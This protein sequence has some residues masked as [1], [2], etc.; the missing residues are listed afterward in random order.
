M[1]QKR[2]G[3]IIFL[4]R[5]TAG[6][7]FHCYWSQS[8]QRNNNSVIKQYL[9]RQL[10][11]WR[12]P[13]LELGLKKFQADLSTLLFW[14]FPIQSLEERILNHR[15]RERKSG[16]I[17]INERLKNLKPFL[18]RILLMDFAKCLWL[19]KVLWWLK[20]NPSSH[21]EKFKLH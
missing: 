2:R 1:K 6:N 19:W 4:K 18:L 10:W 15:K 9:S 13:N 11:E 14:K 21:L 17:E 8:H 3:L 7:W 5:E 16:N 20:L 12:H